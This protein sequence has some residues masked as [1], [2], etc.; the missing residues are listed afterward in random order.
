[1]TTPVASSRAWS[2]ALLILALLA[3]PWPAVAAENGSFVA[4]PSVG[5]PVSGDVSQ[6]A[7]NASGELF[8]TVYGEGVYRSSDGGNSFTKLA[9]PNFGMTNDIPNKEMMTM[10]VNALGE[11]IIGCREVGAQPGQYLFRLDWQSRTWVAASIPTGKDISTD[12][13]DPTGSQTITI[14]GVSIPKQRRFPR[15]LTLDDNGVLWAGWAYVP[16]LLRSFD[17]GSSFEYTAV[18]IATQGTRAGIGPGNVYSFNFNPRTGEYFYGTELIGFWHSTDGGATWLPIDPTGT[19][20]IGTHQNDYSI[21]FN[22]DQEPI[23]ANWG[24]SAQSPAGGDVFT[25]LTRYGTELSASGGLLPWQFNKQN[26]FYQYDGGDAIMRILRVES[27]GYNFISAYSSNYYQNSVPGGGKQTVYLSKDGYDWVEADVD[28]PFVSPYCNSLCTDGTDV[29]VGGTGQVWKFV[30]DEQN[31]LPQVTLTPPGPASL[32]TPLSLAGSATDEDGEPVSL[33]WTARG[34]GQASFS[35]VTTSLTTVSFG[36]PGDYVVTLTADDGHRSAS[37]STIVRVQNHAPTVQTPAAASVAGASFV[38]LSVLGED[39]AAEGGEAGLTYTWFVTTAPPMAV[40]TFDAAGTNAAK[41]TRATINKTGSYTFQVVIQDSGGLQVT[42]SASVVVT[43]VVG[44][45]LVTPSEQLVANDGALRFGSQVNDQFGVALSPQP[46]VTW[47]VSGGG[48]I[49]ASGN[50][51]GDGVSVGS[52]VVTASS[53][54]VS[55]T[56]LLDLVSNEAPVFSSQP[57]ASP[58]TVTL[59]GTTDLRADAFDPDGI[60]GLGVSTVWTKVSGNGAVTFTTVSSSI[61]RASFSLPGVYGLR[62]D[63]S[64]GISTTSAPIT[65]VVDPDPTIPI[66]VTFQDGVDGYTSEVDLS[67]TTQSQAAYNGMNGNTFRSSTLYVQDTAATGGFTGEGLLRFDNLALPPG[68]KVLSASLTVNVSTYSAGYAITGRYL[69]SFWNQAAPQYK[70]GWINR[71][72]NLLWSTPGARGE[73]TDLVAGS[74]F[75]ISGFSLASNQVKTVAL[76]PAV[77]RGWVNDPGSNHGILLRSNTGTSGTVTSSFDTNVARRPKL[78]VVYESAIAQTATATPALVLGSTTA[79]HVL[80]TSFPDEGGEPSLTYT[81]SVAPGSPSALVRFSENG[82]NAA[83]DTIATFS[84]VGSYGLRVTITDANGVSVVSGVDVLVAATPSLVTLSPTNVTTSSTQAVSFSASVIDQFGA[85]ILPPPAVTWA[86]SGGGSIDA[87][88]LFTPDGI[89]TGLF[90]VSASTA[91]RSSSTYVTVIQNAA[92]LIEGV[93]AL[94]SNV[95]LPSGTTLTAVAGDP[96]AFPGTGLVY[97]WSLQSG[98]AAVT[99]T[100]NGS[101]SAASTAAAFTVAGTYVL[102][103]VV[104]DGISTTGSDVTVTVAPDPATPVT[105]SFQQG[106]NGYTGGVDVTITT[107]SRASW[108][109][110]NGNLFRSAQLYVQDTS[111][112]SSGFNGKGLIRFNQLGIPS[113]AVV[114]NAALTLTFATYSPNFSATG[115]YILTSWDPFAPQYKLGWVN[116][117]ATHVWAVQ[118]AAGEGSDLVSSLSFLVSTATTGGNQVRTVNLDTG[119]VQSWVSNPANNQGILLTT[120]TG[121]TSQFSGATDTTVTKRPKLVVTYHL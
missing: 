47:S 117:D 109:N 72:T 112:V 114:T 21:G 84:G 75:S 37:A 111:N 69:N 120:S 78:S 23:F 15:H 43:Q 67:I 64:D 39:L 18:P 63:A 51:T 4:L 10:I 61:T 85:A 92:P 107:Q 20:V 115:R 9:P 83:K 119:V 89:S 30:I 8:A 88:G 22:K 93:T 102:H 97:T 12:G 52:F 106:V 50:F 3:V 11:P 74:S 57:S 68:A 41:V 14:G 116:R 29:F 104:S 99:F 56:A 118:G 81:W 73:G 53:G 66:T 121:L 1:M 31:H 98:P 6:V 70:I 44:A 77:V 5:L 86:V 79:L 55:Q 32:G 58:A 13:Y 42:S 54:P 25:A 80:G 45:I 38:D 26:T 49:D 40:V 91:E 24:R 110:Q 71:D 108:N 48:T 35:S 36:V 76:D 19:T 82:T 46:T 2:L 62:V 100:P 28:Q 17:N 96:D 90:E 95:A 103:V 105:V 94:P 59:P 60:P 16:G 7:V 27:V 113:N 101:A 34:P 65:I 87:G 33:T